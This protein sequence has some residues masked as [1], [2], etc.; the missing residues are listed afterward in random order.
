MKLPGVCVVCR[1]PVQWNGRFW[2]EPGRNGAR[3]HAC[4]VERAVCGAW[5]KN[6]KERCAR[7]PLHNDSHRTRWA[8]DNAL[9]MRTGR[10][11]A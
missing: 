5:M 11:A 2:K 10:R 1:N 9:E 7:A 4:P 3:R 8:M 6:A